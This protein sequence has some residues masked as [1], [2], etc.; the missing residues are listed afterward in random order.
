MPIAE[1]NLLDNIKD[2]FVSSLCLN[3]H[4]LISSGKKTKSLYFAVLEYFVNIYALNADYAKARLKF[5]SDLFV[6]TKFSLSI[7]NKNISKIIRAVTGDFLKPWKRDRY[8]M[9]SCDI[10][11]ILKNKVAVKKVLEIVIKNLNRKKQKKLDELIEILYYEKIIPEV[12]TKAK[13]LIV[14]FRANHNFVAQRELRVIV[15]ANM[16][17]GKSTLINALVGKPVT[18]SSQEAC[19]TNLCFLYNKPFE[20][21]HVHLLSSPINLNASYDDLAAASKD[22]I[23]NIASF[24]RT[25][26]RSQVRVCLIDTPGVN[27]AINSK[28]GK[29]TYKA[30]AEENYDKLIYVLNANLLGTNDEMKYLKYVCKNVTNKKIIFVLNKLD[31]FKDSED[32]ISN[33]IEGIKADLQKIGYKS[34]VICPLSAYFSLLLKMKLNNEKLDEDELDVFDFYQ[35]KFNKPEYDLSKYYCMPDEN[36][37]N[38]SNA[39]LKL[40]LISGL[41]G[42]ENI[43][44]GEKIE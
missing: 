9:L 13:N 18:K 37:I 7:T 44:Y 34:P 2:E 19:T 28:H 5:Y 25:S 31:C 43:L 35:K 42:L 1:T 17:A 38:N 40:S 3:D 36:V 11:I 21:N 33:S 4:P 26:V 41:Y 20:D 39:L 8:I 10:A 27:S 14:Q 16:S 22:A 23:C 29:L 32:S 24:F 12:F 6:N 15:T 30:I